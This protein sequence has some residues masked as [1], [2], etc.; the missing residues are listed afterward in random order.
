MTAKEVEF[1]GTKCFTLG[2]VVYIYSYYNFC[3]LI[4][5]PK[6]EIQDIF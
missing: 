3:K 5:V 2:K 4:D 1:Q 6:P